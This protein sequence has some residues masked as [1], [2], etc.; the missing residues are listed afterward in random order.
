M[1][2][3]IKR[4]GQ[5]YIYQIL[6]I[7]MVGALWL[8]IILNWE[9]C[10]SMQFFSH[11]DGNNILF[12]VGILLVV[13]PFYEVEGKG[14]KVR[15]IGVKALAQDLQNRESEFERN[16]IENNII[17]MQNQSMQQN[18]MGVTDNDELSVSK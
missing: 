11:F 13:L 9:K 4:I 18:Q 10:I 17:M 16:K 5:Q 8:Y 3:K 12:L 2:G 15:R 6:Y 1:I 7:I 14:F